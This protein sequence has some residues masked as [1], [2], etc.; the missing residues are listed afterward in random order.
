MRPRPFDVEVDH[1]DVVQL[2]RPGDERLEQ[3]GRGRSGTVD[4]DLIAGADPSD[5]LIRGHQ[6][7]GDPGN[8]G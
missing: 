5:G 6:L 7:H 4:V 3:D 1:P 8:G 2:R